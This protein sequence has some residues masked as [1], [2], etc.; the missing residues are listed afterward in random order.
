M[1]NRL[2]RDWKVLEKPTST[3]VPEKLTRTPRKEVVQEHV[4][5]P[6]ARE[7][8]AGGTVY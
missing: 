4:A 7:Q 1:I 2:E 8:R 6:A 3:V 5:R